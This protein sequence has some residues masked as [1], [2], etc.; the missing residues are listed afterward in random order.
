[1]LQE[2]AVYKKTPSKSAA[3]REF[4][5]VLDRS[6]ERLE[7]ACRDAVRLRFV[8]GLSLKEASAGQRSRTP[9]SAERAAASRPCVSNYGRFPF[10]SDVRDGQQR[11]HS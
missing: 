3:R 11:Y 4:L 10:T 8:D 7:P 9:S 6:L 5:V 1:M 2:L